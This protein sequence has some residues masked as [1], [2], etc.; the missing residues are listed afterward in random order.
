[1]PLTEVGE[2]GR[3]FAALPVGTRVYSHAET[4]GLSAAMRGGPGGG[5][6]GP[7]T[8]RG[9]LQMVGSDAVIEGVVM[10]ML[11]DGSVLDNVLTKAMRRP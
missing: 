7:M 11:D 2:T 3:E 1:M 6:G 8:I 5:A 9:K 4:M 10:E